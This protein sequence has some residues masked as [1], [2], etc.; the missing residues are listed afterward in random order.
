MFI[1]YLKL[2]RLI[3]CALILCSLEL[4]VPEHWI[5]L[6]SS[7]FFTLASISSGSCKMYVNNKALTNSFLSHCP[8]FVLLSISH[9]TTRLP[10]F[11]RKEKRWRERKREREKGRRALLSIF[12]FCTS[13][14]HEVNC[15]PK[16]YCQNN[17]SFFC[18]VCFSF[19]QLSPAQKDLLLHFLSNCCLFRSLSFS[20]CT[21]GRKKNKS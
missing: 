20:H 11:I 12:C 6:E 14:V 16:L 1:I 9:V 5:E 7:Q 18:C 4:I 21:W 10:G 15:Q 3:F 8:V 17:C 19:F 2:T 13:E